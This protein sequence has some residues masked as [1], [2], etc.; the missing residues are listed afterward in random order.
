MQSQESGI[1]GEWSGLSVPHSASRKPRW[2]AM[3]RGLIAKLLPA[4]PPSANHNRRHSDHWRWKLAQLDLAPDL[5]ADIGSMRW[6]R[7]LGSLTLLTAATL[8]FWPD[9]A[10]LRAAPAMLVDADVRSELR[11]N[12]IAPL[13]FGAR[14]GQAMA[15][16]GAVLPLAAAPE[17]PTLQRTA[18]LGM[19]DSFGRMLQRAGVSSY[20]AAQIEAMVGHVMPLGDL[21]PGTRFSLTL[22]KRDAANQPRPV[23][24]L[25]F[26]GRFNLNLAVQRSNGALTLRSQAIAV[27]STP[28][29]IRGVVG[30]GG[31]YRSARA[32]GAPPSA[33]QDYLRTLSAH[34]AGDG[35]FL[36]GDSFDIILAYRRS[37]NGEVDPG[38][39]LYAGLERDGQPVAQLLRWEMDGSSQFY[40]ASGFGQQQ[41]GG[42]SQPVNGPITSSF[43]M[44]RHP[45][46]GYLR[47]HSGIDFKAS[48]GTPIYAI[49]DGQVEYAGRKGGY[50]NFVRLGHG[51][52]LA[53]GYAHMSQIAVNPGAVVRRGQVIGYV[54]STGLSTG[55]H[56]HYE[57]YRNGQ[58]VNPAGVRFA[59]RTQLDG[60]QLARFRARL[61]QL[62]G[63]NAGAA[64]TT[65]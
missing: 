37:A 46:L 58:P 43:G 64:P 36:P 17:R 21:K 7:G 15:M 47:M 26:R 35:D 8:A 54:G 10:P 1:A 30:A 22:G 56:L 40:E 61:A 65:K 14:S 44:R 59:M 50:G 5:A 39:L 11:R 28:L 55:P 32:S 52:G 38:E 27:D 24:A 62:K 42:I 25:L 57:M 33:V 31:L 48:T 51:G 53:S 13:A 41:Q 18:M 19:G 49:S 23:E 29:R 9:F 4:A 34:F 20:E 12:G 16:T 45:I 63:L 3:V 2:R 60:Q 6:F